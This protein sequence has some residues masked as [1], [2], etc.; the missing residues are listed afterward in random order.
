MK[1]LIIGDV[2]GCWEMANKTISLALGAHPDIERIIQVGDFGFFPNLYNFRPW[3]KEF[4]QECI[5]IDG[6]HDNHDILQD[7]WPDPLPDHM[8]DWV[9]MCE[10]WRYNARGHVEDGILYIGGAKS[11]D[12][13][14]RTEGLDW[15]QREE[16]SYQDQED[17]LDAIEQNDIHT[18]ISHDC[19]DQV[20]HLLKSHHMEPDPTRN[21]LAHVLD[22]VRPERW[23]FGHH[24]TPWRGGYKGTELRGLDMMRK[25]SHDYEVLCM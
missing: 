5:W 8:K 22:E 4:E 17:V 14:H 12:R 21:F 15:W 20:A 7:G 9:K 16:L 23:F 13:H 2:H 11:I 19:P 6:N 10:R 18:V 25:H 3:T 1:T 24:H